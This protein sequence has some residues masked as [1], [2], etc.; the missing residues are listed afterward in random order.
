VNDGEGV[1]VLEAI[2]DGVGIVETVKDEISE[3]DDDC[4][5]SEL[6]EDWAFRLEDDGTAEDEL[7][8]GWTSELAAE[9][10]ETENESMDEPDVVDDELTRATGEE[11]RAPDD[12]TV[13]DEAAEDEIT[14]EEA[15][16]EDDASALQLPKPGWHPVPQ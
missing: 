14:D 8:E 5:E 2:E 15:T 12:E 11:E 10:W 4:M 13:E 16:G 1:G 9:D 7:A 3:L 6:V